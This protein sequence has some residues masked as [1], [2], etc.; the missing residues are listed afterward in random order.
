MNPDSFE[1][2]KLLPIGISL[3]AVIISLV[4]L[5]WNIRAEIQKKKAK[6]E[7]WQRN[8]FYSGGDDE[9][10]KINLVFRNLSHRPTAVIDIYVR[11]AGNGIIKN[12]GESDGVSL[13]L[14]I[15]PW[16]VQ[17][18]NFRIERENEKIMGDILV[19]DVED[20]EI[21]VVRQPNKRWHKQ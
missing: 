17:I 7:V 8:D 19:R 6:L 5:G 14:K 3:I 21:S 9:R 20:N 11:E 18:I 2:T 12:V 4:S 13:P 15:E 16:G 1:I 10:T